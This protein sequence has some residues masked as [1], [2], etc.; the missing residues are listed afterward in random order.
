MSGKPD[1]ASLL[2]NLNS[3]TRQTI[4][5]PRQFSIMVRMRNESVESMKGK[6]VVIGIKHFHNKTEYSLKFV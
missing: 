4:L 6:C 3:L 2:M 5:F 1:K